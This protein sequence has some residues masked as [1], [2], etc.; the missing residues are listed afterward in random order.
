MSRL[1]ANHSYRITVGRL[2]AAA[3]GTS[4]ERPFVVTFRTG[5]R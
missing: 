2:Q 1:A 4:L 5:Y 3:D